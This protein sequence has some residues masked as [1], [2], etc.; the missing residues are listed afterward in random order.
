MLS[1]VKALFIPS[2]MGETRSRFVARMS[3]LSMIIVLLVHAILSL[4][5]YNAQSLV[6]EGRTWA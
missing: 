3:I 2:I 5:V 1:A 6:V 4:S